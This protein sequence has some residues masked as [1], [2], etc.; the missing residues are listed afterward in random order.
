MLRGLDYFRE[1]G[2]APDPRLADAIE[3]LSGSAARTD[4]GGPDGPRTGDVYFAV[5]AP[6][7]EPSQWSTL[8]AM[9]VLRWAGAASG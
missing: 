1:A 4:A 9:R 6:E 7:G 3:L 8:R 5:D 2:D